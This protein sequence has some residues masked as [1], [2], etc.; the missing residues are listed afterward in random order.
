MPGRIIERTS[1]Q[2]GNT[3]FVLTLQAREQH[4]RRSKA[5]SNICTNQ[6]LMVTAATIYMALIG[7]E[8]LRRIAG[9]CHASTLALL[10][11]LEALKGV[12][13]LFT[14]P[15]FHE[16]AISLPSPASDILA[17]LKARRILGGLNLQEYYPEL[18]S[19]ILVCA[20]ETKTPADL[21]HYVDQ[22]SKALPSVHEKAHSY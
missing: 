8:G 4:I 3:G 13:R 5:T 14:G 9:Q 20:T 7:P 10:E 11:K 17:S 22:L 2:V 18:T 12:R 19:S 6:G 1:D 21:D 16:V 15:L